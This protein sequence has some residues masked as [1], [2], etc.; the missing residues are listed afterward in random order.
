MSD[1]S[2]SSASDSYRNAVV[3]VAG[4]GADCGS[5]GWTRALGIKGSF[6][7]RPYVPTTEITLGSCVCLNR[8]RGCDR[9]DGGRSSPS[10]IHTCINDVASTSNL[11]YSVGHVEDA[12]GITRQG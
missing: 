3:S 12:R 9:R 6:A 10:L 4:F 5:R 7:P 2:S 1:S 8:R 11:G